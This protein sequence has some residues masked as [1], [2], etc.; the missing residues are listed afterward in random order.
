MKRTRIGILRSR[1]TSV[2]LACMIGTGVVPGLRASPEKMA[3]LGVVVTQADDT[4]REQLKLPRGI[5]LNVIEVRPD[6]PA[7][8]AGI[9]VHD[10]LEKFDDQLLCNGDQLSALVRSRDPGSKATIT[11][12]RQGKRETVE[13]TLGET[14]VEPEKR[15]LFE[16]W[17]RGIRDFGKAF[18]DLPDFQRFK[19]WFAPFGEPP[20]PR[21][22]PFLGVQLGPVE[23]ALA[24]QLGLDEGTG[25]LVNVVAE[26][27]P[28]YKAGLKEHDV[29]S[30]IDGETVRGPQDVVR[31]IS[32]RK[33]GDKIKLE[34]FRGGKKIEVEAVL[35]EKRDAWPEPRRLRDAL[36]SFQY[37]VV[38][39]MRVYTTRPT[40][41]EHEEIVIE[42]DSEQNEEG[43]GVKSDGDPGRPR[44]RD[45]GGPA[46]DNVPAEVDAK[47]QQPNAPSMT[48]HSTK[49]IVVRTDQDVTTVQEV[50]GKRFVTVKDLNDKVIF[51]GQ[52]NS[53]SDK[54]KLPPN[55]RERL[56]RI[57]REIRAQ[58]NHG[59]FENEV[60][61]LRVP[62]P[63]APREVI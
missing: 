39:R 35:G 21:P 18:R 49:M 50:D 59:L 45:K 16:E 17:Q 55:I 60:H 19:D 42:F 23:P 29:I 48:V 1:I 7:A 47:P 27:S 34:V 41:H 26:N 56:D 33:K 12:I 51:E 63:P 36:K 11:F 62:V 5:G 20:Q 25:A 13:V 8:K 40:E 52:V 15:P 43:T 37:R 32:E 30:K 9:K 57:E 54:E 31:R 53:D 3:Y 28:A 44:M 4:L 58:E 22:S 24:S 2:V 14:E 38:P 46:P 6:T 10:V 61:E